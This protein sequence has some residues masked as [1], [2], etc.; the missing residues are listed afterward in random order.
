MKGTYILILHLETALAHLQVGRLGAYA[1]APGFYLYVGSAFGSGGL[2]ARLAHH[3]QRTKRRPHWHIDYLR[4]HTRLLEVWSM[5]GL[6]RREHSWC[7]ALANAAQLHMPIRGF[8]ASDT[9][10]PSH[11]FYMPDRP[12]MTFFTDLL[13]DDHTAEK[14]ALAVHVFAD[15]HK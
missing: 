12:Q 5:S 3:Q 4:Q 15:D 2:P 1:F 14:H 9:T 13:S 6:P 11:L 10:C 7:A 8:G